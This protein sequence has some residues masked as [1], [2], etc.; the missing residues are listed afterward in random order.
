MMDIRGLVNAYQ[1]VVAPR[2]ALVDET[3]SIRVSQALPGQKLTIRARTIDELDKR[4][5]SYAVFTADEQGVVDVGRQEPEAGSYEGVDS[6]G[7]FWS[8]R[9]VEK[10]KQRDAFFAKNTSAPLTVTIEIEVDGSTI[11][12]SSVER[13]FAAAGVRAIEAREQGLVGTL[14][15]PPGKGPHPAVIT[16]NGSDGGKRD[17]TA[18]LLASHGYAVLALAYFKG[19]SRKL[20]G[21]PA[22]LINIPLEY[23][24]KAIGWLQ[25]RIDVDSEKLAVVGHSRGGELALLLGATFP[26]IKAVVAGSPSGFVH[27]GIKYAPTS[28]PAWT[29]HGEAVPYLPYK[30]TFKESMGFFKNFITRTPMTMREGFLKR[31]PGEGVVEKVSIPVEKT[32]GPILLIAGKDDQLWPSDIYCEQVMERLSAHK[33]GYAYEFLSYE[34]AGH[35]LC[36]PYG[37]PSLPPMTR[38]SPGGGV[39][40]DFGGSARANAETAV[41]SWG[42]I[43]G[44]LEESLRG[45]IV[46]RVP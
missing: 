4:W 16:L 5:Q 29:Y 32:Q 30:S 8:M 36:F 3:V 12:T 7:L 18:A 14:F 27:A 23:F 39:T 13:L 6:M 1:L 44:F 15:M 45:D 19:A 40:I 20:E 17:S 11:A 31:M 21:V 9:R 26:A 37:I 10:G 22:A 35:F 43:L 25:E 41:D 28:L 38:L 46:D 33:F 42:K 24:E 34:G 2:Q